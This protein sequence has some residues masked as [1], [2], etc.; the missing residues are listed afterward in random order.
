MSMQDPISDMLTRIRNAGAVFKA[1]V[2]MPYSKL[3]MAIAEL[4]KEEGYLEDCFEEIDGAHKALRLVL[5]YYEDK[6]VIAKIQ[7]ISKPGLRIYRN[8]EELPQV[9]N[10]L[11]ISIIST[12]EGLMTDKQ[13][14][15]KGLGGEV[16]CA[17]S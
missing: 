8:K 11:G 13:A 17:I 2:C 15:R 4:M 16:I 6:P 5:R 1:D 9:E 12:N 3:K 10:G 14:R 7:K